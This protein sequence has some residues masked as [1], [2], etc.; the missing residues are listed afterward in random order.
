L[1]FAYVF[2][3]INSMNNENKP[4]IHTPSNTKDFAILF[5]KF[6]VFMNKIF[7]Y[8]EVFFL[9]IRKVLLKDDCKMEPLF[10]YYILIN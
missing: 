6:H 10:A 2:E 5:L 9:T 1:Y 7:G 3:N 4:L 8:I